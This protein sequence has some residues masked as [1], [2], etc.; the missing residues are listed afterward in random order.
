[1]AKELKISPYDPRWPIEFEEEPNRIAQRLRQI[2][3]RIDH[4]GSTAVP[5]LDAKPVID[6][7]VSVQQ[8]QPIRCYAEPLTLGYVHVSHVDDAV[9][10]FFH[11][12]REWPHTHH[13]HVAQSGGEE[14]RRT[15]A[16]RDIS[17]SRSSRGRCGG[18]RGSTF[19]SLTCC[20][21]DDEAARNALRHL[22]EVVDPVKVLGIYPE[23][24]S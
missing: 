21:G 19:F 14:E 3:C 17:L 22:A 24:K 12:P 11:R 13:V 9:C 1:M 7:Q 18:G 23:S 2:A 8:L 10:T 6:I 16:L 4:N 20:A 5:G 15:L